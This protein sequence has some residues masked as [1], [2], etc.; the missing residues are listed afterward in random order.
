MRTILGTGHVL[1][2]IP[3][4][5]DG[6]LTPAQR[7]RV[8]DHVERC[9]ECAREVEQD[10][11]GRDALAGSGWPEPSRD[12]VSQLMG[13]GGPDGPLPPRED[14]LRA[15]PRCGVQ[16]A[17]FA[18]SPEPR[19]AP[20]RRAVRRLTTAACVVAAGGAAAV[21]LVVL[22]DPADPPLDHVPT[23]DRTQTV[24]WSDPRWNDDLQTEARP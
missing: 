21:L 20:P 9:V 4:L 24:Q 2:E 22:A 8:L 17:A 10:R 12:L 18:V 19:P 6:R 3:A 1:R 5:V 14:G 7:E 23:A 11:A 13:L 16:V 15:D